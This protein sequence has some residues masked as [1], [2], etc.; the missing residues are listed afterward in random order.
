MHYQTEEQQI[1]AIKNF[2]TKYNNVI[3][4]VFLIFMLAFMV[5]RYW[6]WQQ[7]QVKTSASKLYE[8]MMVSSSQNNDKNIIAYADQ[9]ATSYDNTIYGQAASLLLAKYA[10]K[11]EKLDEAKSRLQHVIAKANLPALR[12][13]AALRF[14]RI[15]IDEKK[16]DEAIKSLE[17]LYDKHYEF[18]VYELKGDIFVAE[19]KS[20]EAREAY[21]QAETLAHKIGLVNKRLELKNQSLN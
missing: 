17:K 19:N 12:Q 7:I 6:D 9:L 21:K 11:A 1:E 16:Y 8:A 20:D 14:A 13:V 15:L 4:A 3:W 5:Y 10:V 2:F 18:L